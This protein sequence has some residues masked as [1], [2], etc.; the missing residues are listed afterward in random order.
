MINSSN[1]F[2]NLLTQKLTPTED[3]PFRMAVVDSVTDGLFLQFYGDE[4]PRE[5]SYKRI[6]SYN[7]MVGDT[8]M[9]AKLNG[10]YTVIGKVV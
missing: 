4:E 6:S 1:E 7:P 10:S 8:V 5:K 9:C 2:A 3:S